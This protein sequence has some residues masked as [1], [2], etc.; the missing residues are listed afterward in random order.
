MSS[1]DSK[2]VT[3]KTAPQL[4]GLQQ[5]SCF[6]WWQLGKWLWCLALLLQLS[7]ASCT[8]LPST[9]SPLMTSSSLQFN[10]GTSLSE[11]PLSSVAASVVGEEMTIL[12]PQMVINAVPEKDRS[13]F[14]EYQMA[15]AIYG[16]SDSENNTMED[17]IE[18]YENERPQ[19]KNVPIYENFAADLLQWLTETF[20]LSPE[21]VYNQLRSRSPLMCTSDGV[22]YSS[23]DLA[24]FCCPF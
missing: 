21:D 10:S 3:I 17:I 12:T 7:V 15:R 8:P 5:L 20:H 2:F 22:C 11:L 16:L 9:A 4:N 6:G 19:I 13:C 18:H 14:L 1:G 24:C 23:D